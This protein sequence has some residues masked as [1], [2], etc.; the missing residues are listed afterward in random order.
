MYMINRR[1]RE[2]VIYWRCHRSRNSHCTGSITTG[3]GDAIVSVKDTHNH[4]PDQA[5]IEVKKLVSTM[6]EKVQDCIRPIPQLYQEALVHV[7]DDMT[8]QLPTLVGVKSSLYRRRRKLIPQ[9]PQSRADVHF[10]G[11]WTQTFK[12]TQF[13]LAEDGVGVDK[14]IIFATEDNLRRLA[15]AGTIHMSTSTHEHTRGTRAIACTH[16]ACAQSAAS[17]EEICN[18]DSDT[19]GPETST[20]SSEVQSFLSRFRATAPLRP[21]AQAQS[22]PE[23]GSRC[24]KEKAEL[25]VYLAKAADVSPETNTLL[26]WQNHSTDLPHWLTAVRDVVLVQP[27]SAA[28]KRV[29]SLLKASFGPQQDSALQDYVQSSIMLQYNNRS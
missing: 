12:G 8:A 1:G 20:D 10:D 14:M 17:A 18:S 16:A 21:D 2:D 19:P 24:A 13:L 23:H 22:S 27:S 3:P 28:A 9:L 15:E 29:F 4:P 26:W 5:S 11:E 7:T 25:S 6:K